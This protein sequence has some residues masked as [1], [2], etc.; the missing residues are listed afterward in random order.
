V[1]SLRPFERPNGALLR[2]GTF[3]Y[4]LST[5]RDTL[6]TQL[7]IRTVQVTPALVGGMPGWLIAESRTGSAMPTIDSLY[8][9]RADLSPERW[10]ASIGKA[11]LA[12]SFTRDSMFG[13]TQ[14][15]QG[16]ASFVAPLPEGALLTPGMVERVVEMLPLQAGFRTGASLV[17]FEMGSTRTVPAELAVVREETVALPDRTVDCWVVALRALPGALE[18]R[19]WVT[20]TAPR[21]V[22]TEQSTSVGLLVAMLQ[23]EAAPPVVTPAGG[24]AG[25]PPTSTPPTPTPPPPRPPN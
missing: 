2:P 21:V 19:M 4:Q 10:V 24:T 15:Y 20:K 1:D 11:Q 18:E 17:I 5:R 13:A 8:V 22:K 14:T 9:A 12:A 7:G 16:R 6:V 3:V 25:A 23:P